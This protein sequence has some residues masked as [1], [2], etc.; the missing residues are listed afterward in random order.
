MRA[1][2]VI[3]YTSASISMRVSRVLLTALALISAS[4]SV[5]AQSIAVS[6]ATLTF[7]NQAVGSTSAAEIVTITNKGGAAQAVV[8]VPSGG[9]TETD[10]CNGNVAGGGSCKVSVY[11]TPTLVGK[12]SGVL[13]SEERRVGKECRSRW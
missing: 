11:F 6:P 12:I 9:F 5:F 2:V 8:I 4:L 13:R 10:T 3:A 1:A 7:A